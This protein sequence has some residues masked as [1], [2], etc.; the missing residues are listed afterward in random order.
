M[1]AN[2]LLINQRRLDLAGL[3]E[4]LEKEAR[5]KLENQI[6]EMNKPTQSKITDYSCFTREQVRKLIKLC[7]PFSFINNKNTKTNLLFNLSD[8]KL[9]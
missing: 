5:E 2:T 8:E 3:K 4:K 6:Y 1:T 9:V 7:P